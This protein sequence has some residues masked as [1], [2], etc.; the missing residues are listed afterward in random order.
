VRFAL[1]FEKKNGKKVTVT[2]KK[3]TDKAPRRGVEKTD[4]T[5]H[6]AQ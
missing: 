4:A 2:K 6:G 1:V 5:G 3:V